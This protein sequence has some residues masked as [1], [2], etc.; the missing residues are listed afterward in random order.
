MSDIRWYYQNKSGLPFARRVTSD[1]F[2]AAL[3]SLLVLANTHTG[4]QLSVE[5]EIRIPGESPKSAPF[6]TPEGRHIVRSSWRAAN[7]VRAVIQ[8]AEASWVGD[9][10]KAAAAEEAGE[11]P[12]QQPQPDAFYGEVRLGQSVSSVM[13]FSLHG[14]DASAVLELVASAHEEAGKSLGYKVDEGHPTDLRPL[15][16]GGTVDHGY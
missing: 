10:L 6:N 4:H 7:A 3:D 9:I 13:L 8:S 2:F 12:P 16:W 11:A 14:Q 1:Q 5:V 15:E